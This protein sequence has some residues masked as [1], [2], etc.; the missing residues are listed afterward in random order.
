MLWSPSKGDAGGTGLKRYDIREGNVATKK[1][2]VMW[3]KEKTLVEKKRE[4]FFVLLTREDRWR[5][6]KKH[7]FK[8]SVRSSLVLKVSTGVEK[9]KLLAYEKVKEAPCSP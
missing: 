7:R 5:S 8:V 6:M 9:G 1:G 3:D 4:R 2:P